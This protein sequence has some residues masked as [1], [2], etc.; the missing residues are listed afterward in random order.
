MK[1]ITL[2][3]TQLTRS[4]ALST[5]IC[6]LLGTATIHAQQ[7]T[8]EGDQSESSLRQIR[9]RMMDRRH[10]DYPEQ[11]DSTRGPAPGRNGPRMKAAE[12]QDGPGRGPSLDRFQEGPGGPAHFMRHGD[13]GEEFGYPGSRDMDRG[14]RHSS[15]FEDDPPARRGP[16]H[17]MRHG[18]RRDEFSYPGSRDMD[19]GPRH[20]SRFED[21]PSA[22]RGPG[23]FMRHGD[24]HEEFSYPGSRDMD[25]GPRHSSRF[26]DDPPARRGPAP[27][28][29]DG[30]RHDGFGHPD[31]DED[32]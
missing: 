19:R 12:E 8:P 28:M 32:E 13:R 27:F 20:S 18:D 30:G 26:E 2:S 4:G 31:F 29:H 10:E 5:A 6:L 22:P 3:G 17:F 1:L 21:D 14:P 11:D 7:R 9:Q 23:H 16:A 25:R 15:R 24:R